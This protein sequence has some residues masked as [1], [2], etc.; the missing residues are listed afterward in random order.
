MDEVGADYA[1]KGVKECLAEMLKHW[2][3]RNTYKE[4]RYGSPTWETLANAVEKSDVALA[5]TIREDHP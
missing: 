3:K 1:Q 5:D 4:A 2:L